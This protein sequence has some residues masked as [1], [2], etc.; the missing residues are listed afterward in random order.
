M[1]RATCV[2]TKLLDKLQEKWP[3]GPTL[4][5][6]SVLSLDFLLTETQLF[7]DGDRRYHDDDDNHDSS[8]FNRLSFRYNL[9]L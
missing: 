9:A 2:A 4:C 6:D 1:I 3:E 5:E 8:F 7:S